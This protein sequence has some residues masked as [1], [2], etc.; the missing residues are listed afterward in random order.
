MLT[1]LKKKPVPPK[2]LDERYRTTAGF[3]PASLRKRETVL[4]IEG[5]PTTDRPG[6]SWGTLSLEELREADYRARYIP[7][8][9]VPAVVA[10]SG[11]GL[12]GALLLGGIFLYLLRVATYG[13]PPAVSDPFLPGHLVATLVSGAPFGLMGGAIIGYILHSRRVL[14][15]LWPLQW[16]HWRPLWVFRREGGELHAVV[17]RALIADYLRLDANGASQ[18]GTQGSSEEDEEEG[19]MVHQANYLYDVMQ[20]HDAKQFYRETGTRLQTLQLGAAILLVV[21]M[22]G[23]L[24][25]FGVA[26]YGDTGVSG[27]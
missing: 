3:T 5:E 1:R 23:L 4:I 13:F 10:V 27:A 12:A 11:L 26:T 9:W 17:P 18:N 24:F 21:V 19:P 22:A 8:T 2:T 14:E 6:I 25:L 20:Q 15:W 16:W 7:D